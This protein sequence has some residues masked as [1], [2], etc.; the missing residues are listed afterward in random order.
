MNRRKPSLTATVKDLKKKRLSS[1]QSMWGKIIQRFH[2]EPIPY[3]GKE[4]MRHMWNFETKGQRLPI[5]KGI[6]RLRRIKEIDPQISSEIFELA[7]LLSLRL[8]EIEDI[9]RELFADPEFIVQQ[10]MEL[11]KDLRRG[12]ETSFGKEV[13]MNSRLIKLRGMEL[14]RLC[15]E[16]TEIISENNIFPEWYA[17]EVKQLVLQ[18]FIHH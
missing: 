4:V 8:P 3:Y 18:E 16:L 7:Q 13:P 10:L 6:K 11:S 17:N 2:K 12:K 1:K 5:D 9:G 15:L 14:E